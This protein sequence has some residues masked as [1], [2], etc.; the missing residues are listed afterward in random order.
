MTDTIRL[1]SPGHPT[2]LLVYLGA[3]FVGVA[4]IAGLTTVVS[5]TEILG[6]DGVIVWSGITAVAGLIAAAVALIGR[7]DSPTESRLKVELV[8]LTILFLSYL[9]YEITLVIGN[10]FGNVV[11]TQVLAHVIFLGCGARAIE[12]IAEIRRVRR[13]PKLGD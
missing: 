11:V 9:W 2:A 10:G 13:E 8:S 4:T 3:S 1:T 6:S 12:V 5:M 7:I